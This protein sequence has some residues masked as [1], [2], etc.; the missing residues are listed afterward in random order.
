MN[1][2][3]GPLLEFARVEH[4]SARYRDLVALR[5]RVLRTPL[6]L[7]FTPEQLEEER[8]DV[9]I[10]AYSQGE[11]V[12][13]VALRAADKSHGAP[14]K[15]RQMA[16][17]PDHQGLGLGKR[18]VVFAEKLAAEGGYR[19]IALHA[20][21]SAVGFYESLG[22]VAE[23]EVFTEVTIPHRKMVKRLAAAY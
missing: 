17:D 15:L 22:Y 2:G 4:N 21:E 6:G 3:I 5:R 20:R 16:V 9:H 10:A 7:D 13:C 11:L 19:E 14:V 18:L 8:A 12:A 23:G 1:S